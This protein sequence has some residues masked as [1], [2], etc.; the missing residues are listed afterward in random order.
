M[1]PLAADNRS[2]TFWVGWML[3]P[4]ALL[5]VAVLGHALYSYALLT[6]LLPELPLVHL[7]P[8]LRQAVHQDGLLRLAQ[9]GF[10]LLFVCAFCACWLFLVL[11]NQAILRE[12]AARPAPLLLRIP[13]G[14]LFALQLMRAGV[15]PAP[16][17]AGE[18]WLAPL[19]W[20]LLLGAAACAGLGLERLQG[21]TTVGE[22]RAGYYWLLASYGLCLALFVLTRRLMRRLDALQRA[23]WQYRDTVGAGAGAAMHLS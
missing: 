20:L 18:R 13:E 4:P 14:L 3:C 2:I 5:T 1:K 6:G 23:Y 12:D 22:W 11:R 21:P 15:L 7:S 19:W 9:A 10:V 8:V 16:T 17:P